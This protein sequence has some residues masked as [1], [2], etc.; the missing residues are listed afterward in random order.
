LL[1]VRAPDSNEDGN[2]PEGGGHERATHPLRAMVGC[3]GGHPV[4]GSVRSVDS[5]VP[6]AGELSKATGH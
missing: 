4:N 6:V 3:V 1:A 5:L 2:E